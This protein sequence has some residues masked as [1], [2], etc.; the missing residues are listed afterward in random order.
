MMKLKRK[1]LV[2]AQ[3]ENELSKLERRI[4]TIA[5]H[6]YKIRQSIESIDRQEAQRAVHLTNSEET[7]SGGSTNRE[8]GEPQLPD[9]PT[10]N[11]LLAEQPTELPSNQ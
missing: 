3:L 2:K 5:E 11:S 6:A 1:K 4:Q 8:S 10:V 7:I 9:N